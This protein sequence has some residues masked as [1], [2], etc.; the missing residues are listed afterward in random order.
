MA[1]ALRGTEAVFLAAGSDGTDGTTTAA[2][3][4]V[5]GHTWDEAERRGLDP[6]GAL[7]GFDSHRVHAALGTLVHTGPTST[8]LGDLHLLA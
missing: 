7:E 5:D 1:R 6:T 2:G 3:A 4:V 8:H